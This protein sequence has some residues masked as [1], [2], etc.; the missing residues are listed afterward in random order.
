M[1]FL[2]FLDCILVFIIVTGL[3]QCAVVVDEFQVF[4]AVAIVLKVLPGFWVV[5]VIR[6]FIIL[7]SLGFIFLLEVIRRLFFLDEVSFLLSSFRSLKVTATVVWSE[8]SS[9]FLQQLF[10]NSVVA[11]VNLVVPL[12]LSLIKVASS[13]REMDEDAY[14]G[15]KLLLFKVSLPELSKSAA[16]NWD[17]VTLG[18]ELPIFLDLVFL[19]SLTLSASVAVPLCFETKNKLNRLSLPFVSGWK[20]QFSAFF[21][22]WASPSISA[23]ISRI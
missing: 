14:V 12:H 10:L 6:N 1:F 11:F 19:V 3:D 15:F 22:S 7:K 20:V 9:L 8:L 17:W 13:V 16:S 5:V 4:F 23:F 2:E 18:F 21:E